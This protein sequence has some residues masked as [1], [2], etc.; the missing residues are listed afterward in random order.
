MTDASDVAVGM[1]LQQYS[2]GQW[3]SISF[4]SKA[5]KPSE[6]RCSTFDRELLAIYL[7]LKHFHYFLEGQEFYM[8]TDHKSL[9]YTLSARTD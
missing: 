7:S 5:L 4:F 6:S 3:C 2:N 1:V 8:M 9:T